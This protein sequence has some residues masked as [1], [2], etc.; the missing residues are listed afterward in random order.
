MDRTNINV[1]L[2]ED[3]PYDTFL[4]EEMLAEASGAF[5]LAHTERLA[6]G[7]ERLAEGGVDVLLLD[8]SLPDSQGFDTFARACAQVPT[9][10]IVVLTGLDDELVAVR[11]VREGAQDYL[12]KGQV[13]GNLL[14]RAIHYAIERKRVE[15][16]LRK[17]NDELALLNRMGQELTA[18]LDLRQVAE[19]FLQAATMIVG[20]EGASV[21][22]WDEQHDQEMVSRPG[23]RRGEG[24]FLVHLGLHP[25]QGIAGWVARTRESVVVASA[26]DDPR[27]FAGV[28]EQIGFRTTSLL[29][30][31]LRAR[32]AVVGVLEVV[33]KWRGEFD[34]DDR[35]LV[36]TL[37]ASA[38]IAIDNARLVEA[39]RQRTSEL[40]ARNEELDAYAHTVAHD[41]KNPLASII[42]FADVLAEQCSTLPR[43]QVHHFLDTIVRTGIKMN[44]IINELLLLA[45]VR[46]L[47]QVEVSV[48]DMASIV[49]GARQRL[50]YVIEEHQA[51]IVVSD[52]WPEALGY[53]P[54]VEEVWVNYLSN[55]LKYGGSPPHVELGA[56]AQADGSVRFWVRDDGAGLTPEEQAR[57]FKPFTRLDQVRAKGHGLGL[58]IVQRIVDRLGGQVGVESEVG[59][60]SVFAFTLPGKPD[61]K[62]TNDGADASSA[63]AG[64]ADAGMR[65]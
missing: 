39:L 11:A 52:V 53:G 27:F 57:L 9:I 21:W 5:D 41:L 12:V 51:E 36:E 20:A 6:A 62:G 8:L 54:W 47:E 42:G 60:G 49:D 46:Q 33:N 16:A 50:S 63:D 28:D 18:T 38:A 10:P 61:V 15:E 13:D 43:E 40:E 58:S 17:R 55:A 1:L 7:L 26:P 35:A 34:A 31:P 2:I 45:S 23:S 30:V 44:S 65:R 22:L 25:G 56:T 24:R 37:V 64:I 4:I 3:N 32:G 14:A 59:Q 48:L 29:A 19:Q